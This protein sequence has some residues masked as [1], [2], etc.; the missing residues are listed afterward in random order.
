MR[1]NGWGGWVL[2]L[3]RGLLTAIKNSPNNLAIQPRWHWQIPWDFRQNLPP[4]FRWGTMIWM[5]YCRFVSLKNPES[6]SPRRS[7]EANSIKIDVTCN[8]VKGE[9]T[10]SVSFLNWIQLNWSDL[11]GKLFIETV[12][13][14]H[15]LLLSHPYPS[16][17]GPYLYWVCTFLALRV[18]LHCNRGCT[19]LLPWA[20]KISHKFILA[21]Y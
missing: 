21:T 11:L 8:L 5:Q 12:F 14:F 3:F 7:N 4:Y 20:Q 9:H 6:D 16:A 15:T 10:I 17:L 2:K 19:F 13:F 1:V 18:M